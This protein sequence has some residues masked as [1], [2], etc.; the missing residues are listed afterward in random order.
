M[1]GF[2]ISI[3]F[4]IVGLG[5]LVGAAQ[6]VLKCSNKEEYAFIATLAGLGIVLFWVVQLLGVFFEQV[7]SVFKLF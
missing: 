1:T 2:D 6:Y 7:K 3:V 4:K 5:I